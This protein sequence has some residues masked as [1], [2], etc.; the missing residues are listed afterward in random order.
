MNRNVV[1]FNV[2]FVAARYRLEGPDSDYASARS[3]LLK[4]VEKNVFLQELKSQILSIQLVLERRIHWSTFLLRTASINII[5]YCR[6]SIG[7]VQIVS[8]LVN[9]G[10]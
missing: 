4:F 10:N 2:V 1:L 9:K 5:V 3:V 6:E 7:M 8:R